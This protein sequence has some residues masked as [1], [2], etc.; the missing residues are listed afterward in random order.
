[1]RIDPSEFRARPLRVHLFLR[2]A[3]LEDVWAIRLPGGG[4]G[5]TIQDVRAALIAGVGAAPAMVKG[6]FHLRGGIG[7]LL[8]WD[9]HSPAWNSESYVHR[10]S[11]AD[12]AES[13]AA[14]GTPDGRLS[15][16]YRFENEQLSER[17]NGTVHAFSSLSIQ[18]TQGGYLAYWAVFVKPV[19][20]LTWLYMKAIAPF[21]R[22]LVYPAII[23]K[24]QNAWAERYGPAGR[25]LK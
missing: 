8:G 16:I 6:L 14:P 7:A 20:R 24:A 18:P 5:R 10:L 19:H 23:R 25:P 13:T 1:M 12:R 4:A 22:W 15:L 9:R 2:D 17:R 3:L 21:R 11:A